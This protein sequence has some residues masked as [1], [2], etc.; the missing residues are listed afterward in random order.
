MTCIHF[1]GMIVCVN[2]WGRLRVG[3]SYVWVD[4]HSYCGPTFFTDAK[5]NTIYDPANESDPVWAEFSRWL[6]KH[7]AAKAKYSAKSLRPN[8]SASKPDT[9]EPVT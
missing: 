5:M 1:G 3:R 8:A 6:D 4:F 7:Q 9:S 2:P